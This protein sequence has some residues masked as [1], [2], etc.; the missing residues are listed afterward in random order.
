MKDCYVSAVKKIRQF[1][2]DK[3]G[4]LTNDSIIDIGVSYDGSWHRR[5]YS[6]HYGVGTIIELHTGLV[7]DTYVMSNYCSICCK[8]TSKHVHYCQKN[9]DGSATAMEVEAASIMFSRSIELYNLRYIRIL[10]DGDAKTVATLNDSNVYEDI[11]II[12]ED[13][14]NHVSKRLYS[15]IERLKKSTKGTSQHLSGKGRVTQKLQKQLSVSYGQALKD[16]A[17]DVH[18]MQRAVMASLF[19]RMSTDSNPQHQYC[20]EGGESWCRYQVETSQGIRDEDR[21]Y[22]HKVQLKPECGELLVP[23]YKR[24]SAPD[25]LKRCT[26]M[27]TTNPNESFNAQ[28]WRRAPKHLPLGK[29]TVETAVAMAVLEFNKG[30]GG[31]KDILEKLQI[32]LGHHTAQ[33]IRSSTRKRRQDAA[34]HSS[35]ISKKSRLRRKLFKAGLSDQRTAKEGLLYES[36]GFNS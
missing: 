2:M 13:C 7:I 23:L 16:G 24:L 30:L 5:G 34:R 9:F 28:I 22:V 11:L 33:S 10:C 20:P 8:G 19:H 6:S 3:D 26:Q 36:G 15:G 17:P 14:V 29:Q 12:K 27:R 1:F 25:L 18:K 4:S 32:P 35:V 31:Y 21:Q